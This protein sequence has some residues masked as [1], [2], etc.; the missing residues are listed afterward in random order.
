MTLLG[1]EVFVFTVSGMRCP[2][3]AFA[4]RYDAEAGH[5][6]DTFRFFG[7]IMAIGLLLVALC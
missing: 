7:A 4:V 2:M 1:L 6:F 5:L 3:T